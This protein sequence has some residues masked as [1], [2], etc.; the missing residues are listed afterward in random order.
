M[1]RT[2]LK[3]WFRECPPSNPPTEARLSSGFARTGHGNVA[4]LPDW[5]PRVSIDR[6]V[7]EP[8]SADRRNVSRNSW[9]TLPVSAVKK[10]KSLH[11]FDAVARDATKSYECHQKKSEFLWSNLLASQAILPIKNKRS[12]R[13]EVANRRTCETACPTKSM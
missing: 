1:M 3:K 8:F 5:R 11:V 4:T 2:I 12:R 7:L 6:P 9:R 10:L 13:H